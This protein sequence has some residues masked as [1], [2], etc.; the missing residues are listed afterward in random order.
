MKLNLEIQLDWIDEEMNLDETVK[1][2]VIDA[3]V[4]KIQKNVEAEVTTKVNDIIDKT[5]VGKINTMTESLF[6]D[7]M[8]KEIQIT[9]NYGSTIKH[10][11]NVTAVIKERFDNFMN[12]TVDEK[13]NTYDGSYGTKYKRLTFIIDKQLQEFANKF[14]TEAVTKVSNEIKVH[15][16]QGLTTKLGSELM[17]VLKV[18]EM[19]ALPNGK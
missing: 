18:N 11:P 2:N 1:Q 10:Y 9:D 5:I 13:G 3:I 12:Q 6:N 4:N 14:T 16:Q 19:L 7:F 17:K 8:N 15:V